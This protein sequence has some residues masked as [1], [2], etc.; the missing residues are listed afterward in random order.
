MFQYEDRQRDR[1][2]GK[3]VEPLADKRQRE[4]ADWLWLR[5]QSLF[6]RDTEVQEHCQDD[7]PQRSC[8]MVMPVYII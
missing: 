3:S 8:L 1:E 4:E 2:T 5:T 6:I 7:R